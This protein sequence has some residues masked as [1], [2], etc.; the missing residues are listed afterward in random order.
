MGIA[1]DHHWRLQGAQPE[2]QPPR[3]LQGVLAEAAAD[4]LAATV[5]GDHIAGV[6]DM[7]PE[8]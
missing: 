3:R 1:G 8:G 6:G 7:G 4:P 2:A 5:I